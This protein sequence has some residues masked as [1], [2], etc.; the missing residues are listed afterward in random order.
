MFEYKFRYFGYHEMNNA[1]MIDFLN[2]EGK[3]GWELVQIIE[4][5]FIDKPNEIANYRF[6]FKRKVVK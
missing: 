1:K 2:K 3:N 5:P 4:K 6:F